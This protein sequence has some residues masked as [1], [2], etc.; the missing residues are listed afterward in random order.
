ME[1]GNCCI[2]GNSSEIPNSSI[3]KDYLTV[4]AV[5]NIMI[6]KDWDARSTFSLWDSR[7]LFVFFQYIALTRS[8]SVIY[9]P[10]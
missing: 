4:K 6:F 8:L 3:A 5:C 2:N 10:Y 7:R 9:F 1:W